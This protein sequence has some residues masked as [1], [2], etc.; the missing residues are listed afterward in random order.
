[1]FTPRRGSLLDGLDC[2]SYPRF[3]TRDLGFRHFKRQ[4]QI[5]RLATLTQDDRSIIE[6]EFAFETLGL[7][8]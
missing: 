3:Q 4:P 2:L 5:F 7:R 1:M 6:T 8:G